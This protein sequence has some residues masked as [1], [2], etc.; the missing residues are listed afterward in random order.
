MASPAASSSRRRH[1]LL[2]LLPATAAASA[3]P[4]A[5]PAAGLP[6]WVAAHDL[7]EAA[8]APADCLDMPVA[9]AA[10]AAPMP[11]RR[12]LDGGA[13][14]FLQEHGLRRQD[15]VSNLRRAIDTWAIGFADS[16]DPEA[17]AVLTSDIQEVTTAPD[18]QTNIGKKGGTQCPEWAKDAAGIVTLPYVGGRQRCSITKLGG[19]LGDDEACSA[20]PETAGSCHAQCDACGR[21][22]ELAEYLDGT[23]LSRLHPNAR[24]TSHQGW[25]FAVKEHEVPDFFMEDLREGGAPVVVATGHSMFFKKFVTR[26]APESATSCQPVKDHKLFNGAV[27]AMTVKLEGT[28]SGGPEVHECRLVFGNLNGPHHS[29]GMTCQEFNAEGGA[30]QEAPPAAPSDVLLFAVR[31]GTSSWNEAKGMGKLK[32]L[33][34]FDAPLTAAGFKDAMALQRALAAG[35]GGGGSVEEGQGVPTAGLGDEEGAAERQRVA[36][37]EEE[38]TARLRKND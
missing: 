31:H 4:P 18:A 32:E 16:I 37:G 25:G 38:N 13:R 22:R 23:Y 3:P 14:A 26:Y 30:A 28:A 20:A 17:G 36:V 9:V 5:P 34:K 8:T 2:L 6:A 21:C 7:G 15:Y 1:L 24:T 19:E 12:F 10:A 29:R 33:V 11:A 35:A 27:L